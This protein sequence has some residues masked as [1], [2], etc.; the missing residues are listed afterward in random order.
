MQTLAQMIFATLLS[1][2]SAAVSQQ[3]KS[4]GVPEDICGKGHISA[5]SECSLL[6]GDSCTAACDAT[7]WSK[8]CNTQ[9]CEA[10]ADYGPYGECDPNCVS[11]CEYNSWGDCTFNWCGSG[12]NALFCDGEPKATSG[13]LDACINYLCDSDKDVDGLVCEAPAAERKGAPKR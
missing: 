9:C 12:S 11:A 5:D 8:Y 10:G 4:A 3:H 1:L 13:E 2:N 7:D 6:S